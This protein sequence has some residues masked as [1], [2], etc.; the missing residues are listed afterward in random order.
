MGHPKKITVLIA[1]D[2]YSNFL[3]MKTI[4]ELHDYEVVHARNGLL[5][6]DY[7]LS[8]YEI[9]LVLMDIKMPEMNGLEATKLIKE[10][11][12]DLPVMAVTS[13]ALMADSKKALDA[14]CDDYLSKPF[15][16]AVLLGKMKQLLENGFQ[17]R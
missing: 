5:A 17:P 7:C 14:G 13:H 11:R 4:L 2:E 9:S 12:P 8:N 6:V 10:K 15:K 1:E 16:S 3:L